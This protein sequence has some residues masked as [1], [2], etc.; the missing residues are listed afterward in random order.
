MF[1]A[2]RKNFFL[3]DDKIRKRGRSMLEIALYG[4][5]SFFLSEFSRE[6]L[7]RLES[8]APGLCRIR[9]L[10][11]VQLSFY[12]EAD[13]PPDLC[14]V[15][16]RDDPERGLEFV[17]DLRKKAGTEVMVIAPG[18]QWAMQ[19]YDA[20]VV[21]YFLDP[22]D[23]SRI[24]PL[25]LR[26]FIRNTPSQKLQFSFRTAEGTRLLAADRIVYVEYSS[27]R[28]LIH[29]DQ[30]QS[31][32]TTTMRSSFGDAAARLLEDSRFIRTHASFLVNITHVTQFG[33]YVLLMDNGASIPI[34]HAKKAEVKRQF[35]KFFEGQTS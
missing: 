35:Q 3:P 1:S 16:I 25:I 30:N 5:D 7:N 19:A 9:Q 2:D 6:L 8:S 22:P 29:T 23:I 31:I 28:L 20:D 32:T 21:S 12:E 33:Q 26:R 34:S 10:S 27:H 15:D 4:N 18:P 24:V 14:I 17:D 11:L 13:A